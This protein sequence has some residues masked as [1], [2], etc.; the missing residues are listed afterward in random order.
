MLGFQYIKTTPTNYVVHFDSGKLRHSGTGLAFFYFKPSSSIAL[1]PIS[2]RDVPFIF[3][4]MTIDFQAIT[5]QGQLTYRIT[6][7]LKVAALLNYTVEGRTNKYISDD[8]E[9]LPQRLV[10]QA[11]AFTRAEVLSRPLRTAIQASQE[12]SVAVQAKLAESK[13]I[14]ALGVEVLALSITAIKPSPEMSRALEAEARESLL[15]NADE[16]IY[17]RRNSAVEQ[18]RRIKENE[19]NTEIAV[20]EKQRQITETKLAADLSAEEKEQHIREVKQEG[21]I[22]LELDRRQLVNAQVE[23]A[24]TEADAQAY[25]VSA[26]LKPLQALDTATL[27][28]LAMQSTDPRLMISMAMK[29]IA[30]NASKIGQF[31]ITPD[32]LG[33]LMN[34]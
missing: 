33:S 2:S 21:A 22:K 25:A 29:E 17:Q 24:H 20:V 8:V 3:N 31:N 16:A 26:A 7:P 4:E 23:N 28:I 18:E 32:L 9:K 19:L 27:Q 1:V 30:Q 13:A 15:R 6:E 10:N 12:I 11:Q 34:K 5:V 14:A